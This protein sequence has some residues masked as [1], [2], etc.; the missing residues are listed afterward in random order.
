R[1]TPAAASIPTTAGAMPD[2]NACTNFQVQAFLSG[3]APAV[4]GM[5]AAAGVSLA[6]SGL[7]AENPLGYAIATLACLLMLRA[8]LNPV[9]IIF[10]CGLLQWIASRGLFG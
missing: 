9:V 4:V 6:R 5:L 3:I 8:K 10:G 1:L 2:R 7:S